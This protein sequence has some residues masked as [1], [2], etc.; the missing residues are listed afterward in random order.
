MSF[1]LTA[2]PRRLLESINLTKH[3]QM[4]SASYSLIFLSCLSNLV[5]LLCANIWELRSYAV[6]PPT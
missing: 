5:R 2:A 4:P 3:Q 6:N 1:N